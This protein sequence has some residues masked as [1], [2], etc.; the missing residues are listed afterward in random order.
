[1]YSSSSFIAW[2]Y[3]VLTMMTLLIDSLQ[4]LLAPLTG[5]IHGTYV[6]GSQL[7]CGLPEKAGVLKKSSSSLN[8]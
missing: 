1:V 7:A 4:N 6:I 3:I 5:R 2:R 8:C